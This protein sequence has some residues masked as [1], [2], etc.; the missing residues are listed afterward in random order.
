M[1]RPSRLTAPVQE[2]V[3]TIL[4]STGCSRAQAARHVGVDV[5]TFARWMDRNAVFRGAVEKAENEYDLG[6]LAR[7][8]AHATRSDKTATWLLEHH[9]RLRAEWA[10]KDQSE[11]TIL[12]RNGQSPQVEVAVTHGLAAPALDAV[13]KLAA[14]AQTLDVM[15][16]VGLVSPPGGS[17]AGPRLVGPAADAEVD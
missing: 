5:S 2:A 1:G 15:V 3:V 13:A 9:P 14:L 8:R 16:R 6:V 17:G 10:T 12:G 11:V 7:V 4:R